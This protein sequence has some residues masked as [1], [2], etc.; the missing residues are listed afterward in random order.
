MTRQLS[1]READQASWFM[2]GRRYGHTVAEVIARAA[3]QMDEADGRT[4]ASLLQD[5]P[6][7]FVSPVLDEPKRR[8]WRS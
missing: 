7:E 8:W 2:D 1:Q 5:A 6:I 4:A 3:Q